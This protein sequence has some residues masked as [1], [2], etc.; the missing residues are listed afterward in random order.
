MACVKDEDNPAKYFKANSSLE[1]KKKNSNYNWEETRDVSIELTTPSDG[2]VNIRAIN[3]EILYQGFLANGILTEFIL[4]IPEEI[5]QVLV[6]YEDKQ[7]LMGV[8]AKKVK[9]TF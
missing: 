7:E 4:K 5:N 8:K 1:E 3:G 2:M 9:F 6:E